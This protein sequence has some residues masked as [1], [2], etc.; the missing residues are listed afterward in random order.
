MSL[1]SRGSSIR[2]L[3]TLENIR[4]QGSITGGNIFI[5]EPRLD[6]EDVK[7]DALIARGIIEGRNLEARLDTAKGTKGLFRVDLKGEPEPFHL[8][9]SIDADVAKLPLFLRNLV[10]D[11][12]FLRE[13]DF[14]KELRG[15]ASGRLVLDR[16][17]TGTQVTV[18]VKEFT[19]HALYQRVPYPLEV[20][21]KFSYDGPAARIM[22]DGLSGN[23]GK[24]SFSRLS[25][26]LTLEGE[27]FINVTSG[28]G[29]MLLDEVY[30][31]LLSFESVQ[32][33]LEKGGSAKGILKLDTLQVQGPLSQPKGWQFQAKAHAEN[34]TVASPRL[35]LPVEITSGD[36]E[37]VPEQLSL[38]H[39]Q[40]RFQDSS[41][42]ISGVPEPLSRRA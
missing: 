3:A 38:S 20:R 39:V 23:A 6:I 16:R 33:S 7:G 41:L 26:Q 19:L 36:F 17:A 4:I 24:S 10:Q 29:V 13:L 35:P 11:E 1:T 9:I 21:G 14:I 27:P 15:D 40:T 32:N 37:A 8:D 22:V 25:G 5:A 42:S 31:W 18:D 2:D 28:S 34:V 30:P 12:A